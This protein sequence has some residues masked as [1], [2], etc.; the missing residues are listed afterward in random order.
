MLFGLGEAFRSG[1]HKAM[2]MDFLE[3]HN[4]HDDK[5]KVYGKTRSYSMIGSSISS[6]IAI[7]LVIY[8]PSINLLFLISI[9]PYVLDLFL[10]LS[11]PN[12]L[13]SKDNSSISMKGFLHSMFKLVY[14]TLLVKRTRRILIDSSLYNAVFK[15]IK[16]YVQPILE[17]MMMGIIIFTVLESDENIEVILGITY[18]IIF[19]ISAYASRYSYVLLKRFKRD[20]ILNISWLLSLFIYVLLSIFIESL[21]AII[22]LFISIYVIQN[23]RKPLMVGKIGDNILKTSKTS[24]LSVE[25]QLTSLFIIAMAPSLGYLYDNFGPRYVFLSLAILSLVLF[26]VKKKEH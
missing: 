11:Y 4:M 12:Y 2:I 1:T 20:S 21:L 10:I 16:D 5:S 23:I 13:N 14:D 7:V 22:L 15:T 25:S 9:I 8:L 24:T 3:Y 19:F 18:A 17:T 26:I 6:L